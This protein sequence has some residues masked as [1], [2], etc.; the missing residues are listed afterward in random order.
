MGIGEATLKRQIA[1]RGAFA[2]VRLETCPG[3]PPNKF[4][5]FAEVENSHYVPVVHAATLY[6]WERLLYEGKNP[7]HVDVR[8]LNLVESTADTAA[9]HVFYASVCAY[10]VA[11]GVQLDHLPQIN[12]DSGRRTLKLEF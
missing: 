3:R 5:V 12:V 1:G 10:C 2:R 11:I 9:M 4:E 6:A 7:P 8:V